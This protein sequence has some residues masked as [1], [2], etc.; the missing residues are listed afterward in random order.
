[1]AMSQ[2]VAHAPPHGKLTKVAALEYIR[3]L[4]TGTPPNGIPPE[5]FG[6]DADLIRHLHEAHAAGGTPRLREAFRDYIHR[7][8]E[9]AAR[10]SGDPP[11]TQGWQVYTL[12]EA[13]RPRPPLTYV[14]E[15]LFPL[16]SLSLVY[17]P[18]GTLKSLLLADMALCAAAGLPWLPPL[19]H[20]SGR[21]RQTHPVSALWV[22]FD[23]GPRLTHAR[24]EALARARN[25]P[26]TI[27]FGYVSMPSPWLDAGLS[28]GLGLRPLLECIEARAAKLVILDNLLMI[29]GGADEN[30]AQMGTVMA[31]L[32]RLSEQTGG[33]IIAIHHQR[34]EMG[35]TSRAG[36]RIRG[37]SSI[38]A[39]LDLAL[40]VEREYHSDSLTLRSTKERGIT[41]PPFGVMFTYTHKVGTKE[42]ETARFFGLEVE[43]TVSDRAIEKA[44]L[45]AVK[46][47]PRIIQKDLIAHIQAALPTVSRH[48][49]RGVIGRLERQKRL[50]GTPGERRS[51]HYELA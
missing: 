45:E 40:L 46:A 12:A 48:R 32:R 18:P 16:P 41:V 42:L 43:D 36:D 27:P 49:I 33:A 19:S 13:Y 28:L 24:M 30:S 11:E 25:L 44:V 3:A 15:G 47:A 51:T 37:H 2:N 4:L 8:P 34:K 5:A 35:T 31:N 23:N 38:E 26:E 29:K 20:L 22:D 17:G 6:D 7:H 39:A 10:F 9:Q 1:M 50:R 21:G 14:V